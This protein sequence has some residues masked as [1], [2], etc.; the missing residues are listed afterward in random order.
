MEHVTDI[1]L[2]VNDTDVMYHVSFHDDLY[3]FETDGSNA[4][5][6]SFEIRRHHNNW[7]P[8]APLD[9]ALANQAIEKLEKFLLSQH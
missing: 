3:A 1:I 2:R 7:E 4:Q 6:S 5:A 9:E 8:V